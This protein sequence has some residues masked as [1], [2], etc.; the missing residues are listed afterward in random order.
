MTWRRANELP[1]DLGDVLGALCRAGA[2]SAYSAASVWKGG[3]REGGV[4]DTNRAAGKT[5]RDKASKRSYRQAIVVIHGMGEHRPMSTLR[6]FAQAALGGGARWFS[7]PDLGGETYELRRL[8][9]LAEGDRPRTLLYEYYWAHELRGNAWSRLTPLVTK[10]LLRGWR[11]VPG[12]LRFLWLLVWTVI[13]ALIIAALFVAVS[14][15]V[16][17]KTPAGLFEFWLSGTAWPTWLERLLA[18]VIPTIFGVLVAAGGKLLLDYFGDVARYLDPHPDNVAARQRIREGAVDLLRRLHDD[19]VSPADRIVVVAHSLG[20]F[21]ALDALR[22]LWTEAYWQPLKRSDYPESAARAQAALERVE[23]LGYKLDEGK[24]ATAEE[25]QAAQRDL[26]L[27][28]SHVL[29][30]WRVSDLITLG[31]P[32]AHAPMLLARDRHELMRLQDLR[33]LPRCPPSLDHKL[34]PEE[35][36][37]SDN[38]SSEPWRGRYSYPPHDTAEGPGMIRRLHNGA[39][40]AVT[41]WT[42]VWFPSRYGIF[43]DWFGGPLAPVL[44]P[45]V[46]D[47]PI[48]RGWRPRIPA[49]AHVCYFKTTRR[50]SGKRVALSDSEGSHLQLL[51]EALGLKSREWLPGM[52]EPRRWLGGSTREH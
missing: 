21:V 38:A 25:F 24:A 31:S 15:D 20:S 18:V 34:H 32:L 49:Y 36:A 19:R 10:F 42:N 7:E 14:P 27:A 44:G 1:D 43:G 23:Q 33:E 48:E 11:N 6:G 22:F 37:R 9:H 51:R 52:A 47:R 12:S 41:R 2:N 30:R 46:F 16:Q 39:L 45:G 28:R 17:K 50:A 40:F 8:Y 13:L 35:P 29:D 5:Q 26:L 4:S 3:A